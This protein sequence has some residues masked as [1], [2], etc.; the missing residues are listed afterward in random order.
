MKTTTIEAPPS[1]ALSSTGMRHAARTGR[2]DGAGYAPALCD[3]SLWVSVEHTTVSRVEDGAARW[4]TVPLLAVTDSTP[5]RDDDGNF[6]AEAPE[7]RRCY[8]ALGAR[9]AE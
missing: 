6:V 2:M 1:V 4:A 7:C 8:R 9:E 5:G 3:Q